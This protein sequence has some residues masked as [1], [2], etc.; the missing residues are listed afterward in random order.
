MAPP[1]LHSMSATHVW[2]DVDRRVEE[3]SADEG[4]E[5]REKDGVIETARDLRD[6]RGEEEAAGRGGMGWRESEE[7]GE[8]RDAGRVKRANQVAGGCGSGLQT[9]Y[10]SRCER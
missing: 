4:H 10:D 1:G 8:V 5:V 2:F 3:Q 7:K 6:G 9:G